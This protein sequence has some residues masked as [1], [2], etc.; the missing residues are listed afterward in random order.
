[1][2][3]VLTAA[4]ALSDLLTGS[5]CTVEAHPVALAVQ[6]AYPQYEAAV[7]GDYVL[8]GTDAIWWSYPIPEGLD[9]C[10]GGTARVLREGAFTLRGGHPYVDPTW[11][12]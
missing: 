11:P 6:R 5:P 9:G 2:T 1:M 8:V 4:I 12:S 3:P 7:L 10:E